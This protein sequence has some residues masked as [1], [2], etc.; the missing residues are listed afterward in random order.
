MQERSYCFNAQLL[1]LLTVFLTVHAPSYCPC[2]TVK[3]SCKPWLRKCQLQAGCV[4]RSNSLFTSSQCHFSLRPDSENDESAIKDQ[5]D[6]PEQM[7]GVVTDPDI[8][9]PKKSSPKQQTPSSKKTNELVSTSAPLYMPADACIKQYP[10]P[11]FVCLIYACALKAW[12]PC[13]LQA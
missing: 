12:P 4:T 11:D 5:H 9:P 7:K 6:S 2:A 10:C 13:S 8:A 1:L 3:A